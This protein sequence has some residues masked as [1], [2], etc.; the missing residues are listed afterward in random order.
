MAA[1]R[2]IFILAWLPYCM[3]SLTGPCSSF[4][5]CKFGVV[6]VCACFS[7]AVFEADLIE[8][9][10]NGVIYIIGMLESFWVLFWLNFCTN[11]TFVCNISICGSKNWALSVRQIMRN[12]HQVCFLKFKEMGS[13]V[14]PCTRI[15]V[16]ILAPFV[17]FISYDCALPC[18]GCL[19]FIYTS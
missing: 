15:A 17:P 13:F 12:I 4:H 18:F 9:M 3:G 1:R 8:C 5:C 7:G 10:H 19:Y 11:R 6:F 16:S 14:T 2:G